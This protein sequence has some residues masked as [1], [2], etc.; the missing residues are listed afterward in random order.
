MAVRRRNLRSQL[1]VLF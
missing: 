1:W